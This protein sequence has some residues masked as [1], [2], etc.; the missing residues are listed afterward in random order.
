PVLADDLANLR[1]PRP[2]GAGRSGAGGEGARLGGAVL[3]RS[4]GA[5]GE[6]GQRCPR[7][8]G[9]PGY[10]SHPRRL[11]S[12]G[13]RRGRAVPP[14]VRGGEPSRVLAALRVLGGAVRGRGRGRMKRLPLDPL[15]LPLTGVQLI[16]A[17]AGTGKTYTITTIV[18]RLLLERELGI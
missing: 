8:V 4:D 9:V 14:D 16:E 6:R 1:R 18:L 12:G 3:P 2:L 7:G 15:R 17:S 13:G 10:P 5:R 11:R